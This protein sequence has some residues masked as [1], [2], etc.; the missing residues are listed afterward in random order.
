LATAFYIPFNLFRHCFNERA[1]IPKQ[2]E[3]VTCEAQFVFHNSSGSDG[4]RWDIEDAG[5]E[6]SVQEGPIIP[7]NLSVQACHPDGVRIGGLQKHMASYIGYTLLGYQ[8][9]CSNVFRQYNCH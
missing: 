6:K 2:G 7:I 1:E 8:G 5:A 9:V 4:C 3:K